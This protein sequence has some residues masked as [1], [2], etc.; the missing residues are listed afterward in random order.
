[1]KVLTNHDHNEF[2]IAL[3]RRTRPRETWRYGSS[4]DMLASMH[5]HAPEAFD[6][7]IT[8]KHQQHLYMRKDLLHYSYAPVS[9]G[10]AS[11]DTGLLGFARSW[12]L[13]SPQLTNRSRL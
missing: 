10:P 5:A 13:L 12:L 3:N 8:S 2:T 7:S 4:F 1:M 9:F 6:T 11:D